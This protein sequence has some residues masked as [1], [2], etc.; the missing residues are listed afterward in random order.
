MIIPKM[1]YFKKNWPLERKKIK[2]NLLV[3][4]WYG[5]VVL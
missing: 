3:T 1:Q 2:K 4:D 5:K